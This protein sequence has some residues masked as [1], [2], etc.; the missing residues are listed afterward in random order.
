M[1]GRDFCG[2]AGTEAVCPAVLPQR[3][4]L[5]CRLELECASLTKVIIS[6]GEGWLYDV[7]ILSLR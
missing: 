4:L 3:G 6:A 2:A 7:S 5:V 1:N